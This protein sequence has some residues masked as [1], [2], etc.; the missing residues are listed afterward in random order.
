MSLS[1]IPSSLNPIVEKTGILS[2]VW[3]SFMESVNYWLRPIGSSGTTANRPVDTSQIPL[4]IGQTYFDT[5]LNK[6]IWVKSKN[7][8]VWI[9]ATG[10][11][12]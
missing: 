4:Y 1:P 9:D 7:P 2:T 11:A 6:P 8:T 10:A 5:T 12:V 3:R